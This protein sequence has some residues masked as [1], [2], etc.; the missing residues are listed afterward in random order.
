MRSLRTHAGTPFQESSRRCTLGRTCCAA[1]ARRRGLVV[2]RAARARS[3][4]CAVSASSSCSARTI[5]PSTSSETPLRLPRSSR[6]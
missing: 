5:E 2:A 6:A 4:R 3:N 1:A